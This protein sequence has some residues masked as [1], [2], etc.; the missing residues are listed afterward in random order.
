MD[1]TRALFGTLWKMFATD[2]VLTLGAIA[3]VVCLGV[4]LHVRIVQPEQGPFLLTG[5]VFAVFVAAVSLSTRKIIRQRI[6]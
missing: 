3:V 6:K 4:L 2:L 1:V 5:L